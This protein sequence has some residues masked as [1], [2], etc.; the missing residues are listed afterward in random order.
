L[1]VALSSLIGHLLLVIFL[2]FS[3]DYYQAWAC[4]QFFVTFKKSCI[5]YHCHLKT[6]GIFFVMCTSSLL[7][8]HRLKY[9]YDIFI[10]TWQFL[11]KYFFFFKI[12]TKFKF[13]DFNCMDHKGLSTYLDFLS[14]NQ[15]VVL[16]DWQLILNNRILIEY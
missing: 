5:Y 14:R 8:F 2:A 16:C 4:L 7:E 15:H 9:D 1:F 6:G 3:V 10:E 13:Y 11:F 12:L